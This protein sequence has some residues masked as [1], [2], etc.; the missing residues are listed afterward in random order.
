MKTDFALNVIGDPGPT[1]LANFKLPF[2]GPFP[3]TAQTV[4]EVSAIIG[5]AMNSEN[6]PREIYTNPAH[7][8][9]VKDFYD[10][11]GKFELLLKP[12][13]DS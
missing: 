8:P 11:V 13:V 7:E 5:Q 12:P 4:E 6:P 10:D 2:L 3:R 9:L 1:S